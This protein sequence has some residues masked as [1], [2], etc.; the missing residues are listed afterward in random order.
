MR[1]EMKAEN[2]APSITAGTVDKEEIERFS[3]LADGWWDPEGKFRPLHRIN[4]LRIGYIRDQARDHFEAHGHPPLTGLAL[5]D[6]GC[7]GGLISEPMARLGAA[8]TAIDAAEKN[9]GVAKTHAA[10][11]GLSIDYRCTTAEALAET[12]AQFDI[13]LALEVIEH[14]ADAALFLKECARLVRPG[15]LFF[16]STINRTPKAYAMAIIG[17]EYVLRWL[18]RGT[19]TY[20]KFLRPSEVHAYLRENGLEVTDMQGMVFRLGKTEWK[21]VPKDLDVNYLLTAEKKE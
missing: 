2:A 19:H 17:A 3:R 18:P 6:I 14:V 16:L 11:S 13:V 20:E 15:G 4:P 1:V 9:I 5:L 10:Q 8:V 21:L 7:G 12:G